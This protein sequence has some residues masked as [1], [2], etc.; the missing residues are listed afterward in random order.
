M[1]TSGSSCSSFLWQIGADA[2][3]TGLLES[4]AREVCPDAEVRRSGDLAEAVASAHDGPVAL[5]LCD[6]AADLVARARGAAEGAGLPRWAVVGAGRAPEGM[7]AA[8]TLPR[9]DWSVAAL[10]R[11][12]RQAG[13]ELQLRRENARLRGDLATFGH[14][15]AHDLRTPLGGVLT[16]TEM[17][18]EILSE[19][20]PKNVALTQPILDSTDGLVK[21]IE[22]VSLF[23]KALASN[24]PPQRFSMSQPFWNAFQQL[25][26]HLLQKGAS[27][28]QPADWPMVQGHA[29]W[30]QAVWRHLMENAVQHG[31]R[32]IAA[33]WAQ[34]TAGLRFW[35][36]DDGEV[37][38]DKRARLFF[39]FHRLHEPGAPRGL[40]LPMVSALIERDGGHCGFAAPADG[41]SEFHFVL[42][43]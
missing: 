32:R 29:A 12:L 24:E 42:P 30:L 38:P 19:D 11:A 13:M 18:R 15:I 26:S 31:G 25:E 16:T 1:S 39:P 9:T 2:A 8:D 5:V 37:A 35:L 20:C 21:L 17:L 27:L 28:Q 10:A 33:G 7:A 6:P 14:R 41:G 34:E 43:A 40:G 22:R 3:L 4:A 23:A 36:R